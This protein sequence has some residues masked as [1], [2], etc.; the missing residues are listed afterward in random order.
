[1]IAKAILKVRVG[2]G[3]T[4]TIVR[5]LNKLTK[6]VKKDK[7]MITHSHKFTITTGKAAHAAAPVADGKI[8]VIQKTVIHMKNLK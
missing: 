5:K 6:Y 3:K 4:A 2:K 1:M 8:R 7:K